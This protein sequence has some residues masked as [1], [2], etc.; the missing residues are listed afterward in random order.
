MTLLC[1]I[2]LVFGETVCAHHHPNSQRNQRPLN[3]Y[4]T[5]DLVPHTPD[6]VVTLR[7][8]KTYHRSKTTTLTRTRYT[9]GQHT[10]MPNAVQIWHSRQQVSLCDLA[11]CASCRN[12]YNCWKEHSYWLV[13]NRMNKQNT[14]LTIRSSQCEAAP[15]CSCDLTTRPL[16]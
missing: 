6:Q 12:W 13:S 7:S 11:A 8:T 2:L 5:D 10:A 1:W 4:A 16:A 3:H 9:V 14:V 15:Y